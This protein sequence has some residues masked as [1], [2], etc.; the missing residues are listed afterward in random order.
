[1]FHCGSGDLLAGLPNLKG[2]MR[3]RTWFQGS[4]WNWV[5]VS[6]RKCVCRSP[7]S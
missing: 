2:L 4:G 6:L 7:A 5:K 3:V 1:M